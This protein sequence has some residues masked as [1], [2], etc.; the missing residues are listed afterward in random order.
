MKKFTDFLS[1]I[2][3]VLL[4]S[5]CV[6]SGTHSTYTR[7]LTAIEQ[8]N[9]LPDDYYNNIPRRP[10]SNEND[11]IDYCISLLDKLLPRGYERREDNIF[12]RSMINEIDGTQVTVVV[13]IINNVVAL[14]SFGM[15]TGSYSL[16]RSFCDFYRDYI[17][18]KGFIYDA[19]YYSSNN[20]R[21][22]YKDNY[23]IV[24]LTPNISG[25]I[26]NTGLSFGIVQ[27]NNENAINLR[28]GFDILFERFFSLFGTRVT[29]YIERT[30]NGSYLIEQFYTNDVHLQFNIVAFL[31]QEQRIRELNIIIN[32]RN[33]ID[34]IYLLDSLTESNVYKNMNK[35]REG[36]KII[37]NNLDYYFEIYMPNPD[38]PLVIFIV[39]R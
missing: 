9:T 7:P 21:R 16:A 17:I 35:L 1:L 14:S 38:E 22:Y 20:N 30:Y 2:I 39:K 34:G 24:I 33:A 4:F 11:F 36:R 32:F 8:R 27:N 3:I 6:T 19:S 12:T 18:A 28:D 37:G 15:N 23:D 26:I 5:N 10:I 25:S 29:S 13:Q 31:D